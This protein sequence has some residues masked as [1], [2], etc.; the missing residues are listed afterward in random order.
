MHVDQHN[1]GVRSRDPRD[2]RFDV[3]GF[4]DEIEPVSQLRAHAG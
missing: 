4:T 3:F 2:G 1:V